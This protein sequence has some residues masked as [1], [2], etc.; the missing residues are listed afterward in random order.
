[1]KYSNF[2]SRKIAFLAVC[3]IGITACAQ[4]TENRR[5][6][7]SKNLDYFNMIFKEL[8]LYYVDS[9]SPEKT[10]Q[11][12]IRSMLSSLDP[13]N[14]FYSE[15]EAEEFKVRYIG[16]Y[17][18]IGSVIMYYKDKRVVIAEPYEGSPAAKS[19]LKIGDIILEING[20]SV[21]GMTTTQVSERLRGKVGTSLTVKVERPGMDTPVEIKL[22]RSTI[23]T[24][25]VPYYGKYENEV[26]Y[27]YLSSFIGEP[28]KEFKNAFLALRKEGIKSLVIDLRDN[29]GGSMDDAVAIANY[30]LPK[31]QEVVVTK[32]KSKRVE[33]IYKT[34]SNPLDTEIPLVILVNESSASASEVL[35]GALQDLDRAVIVGNRTY[36]KGLVQVA[37]NLPYG[38]TLK[39]TTAKYYTPS[40]RSVQAIDYTERDERGEGKSIPDSLTNV[41]YTAAG[42]EVR[43]GGGITPD[44]VTKRP[45]I[46]GM[47]YALNSGVDSMKNVFDFAT[48][49][50]LRHPSIPEADQFEVSDE[51]YARFKQQLKDRGFV[52]D[53]RSERV[54]KQLKDIIKAEGYDEITQESM[55]SLEKALSHDL[56]RDLD[57]FSKEVR[58]IIAM[59]I[60]KRYYYQKG[61]FAVLLKNDQELKRALEVIQNPAEY[62][63]ILLPP[64]NEMARKD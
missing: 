15:E 20:E 64:A 61:E 9:I 53:L 63:Q 13:Y 26:G 3:I 16:N 42:R 1:M 46:S 2:S 33:R 34:T 23:Q 14:E 44:I 11:T 48:D 24:P 47:V 29:T 60:V 41:F 50:Y 51:E 7:I 22:V 30:F 59:E 8:D 5:F 62:R 27:I 19:G 43:D 4:I 39:L 17:G 35:A 54:L 18:G 55:Q 52:Y 57:L 12:G 10:I 31:G 21:N 58:E 38:A 32:G 49:F 37:R 6:K 56:D 28:A 40:G 25:T 36:G 45:E